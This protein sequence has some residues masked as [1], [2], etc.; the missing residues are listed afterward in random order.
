M[1]SIKLGIWFYGV[2]MN[3]ACETMR[4]TDGNLIIRAAG[5]TAFNIARTPV[6]GWVG[7]KYHARSGNVHLHR[8][9]LGFVPPT[10]VGTRRGGLVVRRTLL[11]PLMSIMLAYGPRPQAQEP[12]PTLKKVAEFDLPGPT[13]K[14]FDYL[15]IDPDDHYLISAHLA[16]GLPQSRLRYYQV[17][18][19]AGPSGRRDRIDSRRHH[20]L[21]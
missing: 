5:V 19:G 2:E 6:T 3:D 8:L 20:R 1:V 17:R 4:N 10:V 18:R 7:S 9:R 14:R 13:G 12:S 16:A 21:P 15:T 11:L